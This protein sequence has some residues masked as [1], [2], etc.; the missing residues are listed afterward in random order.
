VSDLRKPCLLAKRHHLIIVLEPVFSNC[1]GLD[2]QRQ[3]LIS[4]QFKWCDSFGHIRSLIVVCFS[5]P[6]VSIPVHCNFLV[7]RHVF[8]G[9]IIC[10]T[11][12]VGLLQPQ[13]PPMSEILLP[14]PKLELGAT[15]MH[16]SLGRHLDMLFLLLGDL[17][18]LT[19]PSRTGGNVLFSNTKRNS[20]HVADQQNIICLFDNLRV[21]K[22]NCPYIHGYGR[23][24]SSASL[25]FWSNINNS[26][27][28]IKYMSTI[29][30]DVI[31]AQRK[32]TAGT[33][34]NIAQGL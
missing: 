34:H 24:F 18:R 28:W 30:R 27:K 33:L 25:S 15:A 20:L 11:W 12:I 5:F 23:L 31:L 32:Q 1:T 14:S 17:H 8:W 21:N 7:S 2:N 10:A 9:Y 22:G 29:S 6:C 19:Y 4:E 3:G 16:G 26:H 13:T